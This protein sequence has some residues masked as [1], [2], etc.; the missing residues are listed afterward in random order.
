[1]LYHIRT[2]HNHACSVHFQIIIFINSK[3]YTT[4]VQVGSCLMNHT[5]SWNSRR[6]DQGMGA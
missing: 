5:E 3:S 1:M 2:A 6:Q 4:G